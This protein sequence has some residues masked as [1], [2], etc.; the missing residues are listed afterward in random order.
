M[1]TELLKTRSIEKAR[2]LAPDASKIVQLKT[3]FHL[4]F[5]YQSEYKIW[6][7]NNAGKVATNG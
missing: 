5:D 7:K 3:G 1:A 4:A 2:K 6:L